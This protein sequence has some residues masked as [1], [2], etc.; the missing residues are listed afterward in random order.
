MSSDEWY[1]PESFY[2]F[3]RR[4]WSP[5]L[6]ACAAAHSARAPSYYGLDHVDP[7]RRNALACDWAED[8]GGGNVWCNPPYSL[9]PEFLTKARE[10]AATPGYGGSVVCLVPASTDT[11][12]FRDATE[13]E[14]ALLNV[15]IIEGRIRFE[16]GEGQKATSNTHGSVLIVYGSDNVFPPSGNVLRLSKKL[17]SQDFASELP[18]A[19]RTGFARY[20][21]AVV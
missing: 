7:T 16:A 12:W 2:S 11:Q 17:Q 19:I 4:L 18:L 20:R 3:V 14:G 9:K 6:D 10:T 13:P 15:W 1:T 8:A 21:W 5:S